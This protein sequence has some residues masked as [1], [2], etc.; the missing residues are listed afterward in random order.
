MTT[1][2]IPHQKVALAQVSFAKNSLTRAETNEDSIKAC[3]EKWKEAENKNPFESDPEPIHLFQDVDGV[4]HIGDGRTRLMGADRAGRQFVTAIIEEGTLADAIDFGLACNH[5]NGTALTK[6]D[7]TYRI[8]LAHAMH[9]AWSDKKVADTLDVSRTWVAAVRAKLTPTDEK[10]A[11]KLREE[12]AK[13]KAAPP[14]EDKDEA[15]ATQEDL[16]KVVRDRQ[17]KAPSARKPAEKVSKAADIE[18]GKTYGQKVADIQSADDAIKGTFSSL[19]KLLDARRDLTSDNEN[20][21]MHHDQ[22]KAAVNTAFLGWEAWRKA[23]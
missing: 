23:T 20:T 1:V 8:K 4:L 21:Q 19:V 9:P 17:R 22:I 3:A 14:V 18:R 10:R 16:K 11:E 7:Q 13:K 15:V 12:A 5:K 6:R 2:F